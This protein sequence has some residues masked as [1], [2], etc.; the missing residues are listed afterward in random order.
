M[1][2]CRNCNMHYSQKR[3]VCTVHAAMLWHAKT[4]QKPSQDEVVMHALY[5]KLMPVMCPLHEH[6]VHIRLHNG[7]TEGTKS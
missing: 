6:K 5:N 1:M 3:T 7:S 2:S 4:G